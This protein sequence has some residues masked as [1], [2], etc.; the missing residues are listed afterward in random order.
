MFRVMDIQLPAN[1]M[2]TRGT[3]FWL[4]PPLLIVREMA[5]DSIILHF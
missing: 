3:G 1:L 5:H 2:F 4:T